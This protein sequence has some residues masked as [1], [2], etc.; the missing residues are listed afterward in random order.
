VP[1]G[2]SDATVPNPIFNLTP[3]ATVDEGNNWI[4]MRWGPLSL[5]NP[6]T[7]TQLGNYSLTAGSLVIDT[8]PTSEPN[9]N[10]VPSLDFFGNSR[11]EPGTDTH[12][13]PGAVE[14]GSQAPVAILTVTG[15]PLN[16]GN[17]A[18]GTTSAARTLTLRNTGTAGA[19]SI[20]LSFSPSVF[21]RATAGGSCGTTLAVGATCTINVTFAPTAAQSYSGTLTILANVAVTGSPVT[22]TGTGTAAIR[23]ATVAPS[24]LAFGNWAVGTTSN[25]RTLT[26]T[27]TGNVTLTGGA[28]AIPAG[29]FTRVAAGTTCAG[30]LG[31]GASCTYN[32]QFTPTTVGT[33]TGSVTFTY[34][35]ATVTGS[36]V[37]LTG[38]GVA[39][40]AT[41]S[42][43]PNPLT[44]TL[45]T[46]SI[47]G[48]GTVTLTNT[49]PTTGGSQMT[50]SSVAVAGG[51]VT[52]YF[53][54]KVAGADNCTG[55]TLAPGATC[56]VGVRFTNSGSGRGTTRTG[57]ITF[58]DN[59]TGNPQ[60]GALNG[61][62]T[63]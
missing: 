54:N 42:I 55:T 40:R 38:T 28:Q 12:F 37:T 7:K 59:G 43:T 56:T 23:T 22:L 47:T 4:N 35:G 49:A 27:N 9:F 24:P 8:V 13:D 29:P 32:V 61:F 31:V 44:I 58:T 16:F 39:A 14:I 34:T 21:A 48:T 18:V 36:P 11:P 26:V 57:T 46:G 2:I 15:G 10:L 60:V 1:A 33:V 41:V 63:P 52:T 51:T 45:P 6:V 19:S 53:F 62:A 20:A 5:L 30:T 25:A 3:V 50:V 17:V